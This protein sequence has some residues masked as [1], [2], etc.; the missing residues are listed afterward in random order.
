MHKFTGPFINHIRPPMKR[1]NIK[2]AFPTEVNMRQASLSD[3]IHHRLCTKTHPTQ[4]SYNGTPHGV[5]I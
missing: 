1:V 4:G 3:T 2:M 5:L